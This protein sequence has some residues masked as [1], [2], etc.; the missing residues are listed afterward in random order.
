MMYA[1]IEFET[2]G[3][4]FAGG[5]KIKNHKNIFLFFIRSH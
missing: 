5:L 4:F 3:D 2:D 1:V